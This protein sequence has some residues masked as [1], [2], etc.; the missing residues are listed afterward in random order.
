MPSL[1]VQSPRLSSSGF[2]LFPFPGLPLS[3]LRVQDQIR[4]LPYFVSLCFLKLGPEEPRA[5]ARQYSQP[6]VP[7]LKMMIFCREKKYKSLREVGTG[8]GTTDLGFDAVLPTKSQMMNCHN[9][10]ICEIGIYT[11]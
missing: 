9:V 5:R 10:P 6:F 2:L 7:C 4:R 11:S 8:Y 1:P 3:H